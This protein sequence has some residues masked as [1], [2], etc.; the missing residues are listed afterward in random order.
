MALN[1][2]L[3]VIVFLSQSY[4][5]RQKTSRQLKNKGQSKMTPPCCPSSTFLGNCF[6]ILS[7]ITS[8]SETLI[9]SAWFT[10]PKFYPQKARFMC[11][12]TFILPQF[13]QL[14][15]CLGYIPLLQGLAKLKFYCRMIHVK[16]PFNQINLSKQCYQRWYETTLHLSLANVMSRRKKQVRNNANKYVVQSDEPP[17]CP[18]AEKSI[19]PNKVC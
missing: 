11:K 2:V 1:F 15:D 5:L 14:L 19:T 9:F 7:L 13:N 4:N 17:P 6:T 18:H 3:L 16:A 8:C 10:G 12:V